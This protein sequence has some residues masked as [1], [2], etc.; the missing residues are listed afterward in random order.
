MRR[1]DRS[2]A[3]RTRRGAV[4]MGS[5]AA[6]ALTAI[7]PLSAASADEITDLGTAS[8]HGVAAEPAGL[9]AESSPT[10]AWLVETEGTPTS[11]GGSPSVNSRHAREVIAE[12]QELGVDLS[13]RSE[14]S[15]LWTGLSVTMSDADAALLAGADGVQAV[16]PVLPLELPPTPTS[17][18]MPEMVSA[19]TMTGADIAQSELGY[20][21]EGIAVGIIDTGVDYHHPDLGGSGAETTFPTERVPVGYDFVGD[22]YNADDSSVDYQPVPAPDPDPDDC[23]SHGTHVA[24]IVGAD[25]DPADGG[26]R[27]VAPGVTFGAYRVFGCD[28]STTSDIMIEAMER[29]LDDGMDVVNMSIGAAF[30]SWPE[31][32]T[33]VASAAL[34]DAGVVVVASIGNEGDLGLWAAGAPGVGDDV[35][36]VASYDNVEF[37]A[38]SFGTQPDG[39]VYP[40]ISAAGA[41]DAPTSGELPL[42]IA[43]LPLAC[44]PLAGDYSGQAVVVQR[45]G[46]SFHIKAVNAQDA[47][48]AAMVLYNN[49]P[50][51]VSPTVEGETP[52]TIA[53]PS[54]S[55]DDGLALVAAIEEGQ[56][57]ELV[58]SDET[59]SAPNPTGGLI[60]DFSS[61]GMTADL[62]LKPDLG[63]PGGQIWSTMPL[64]QGGYG[65]KSGTSMAS[66][67]V[68]GAIALLLQARDDLDP[69]EIKDVL[70]NSAD[71][72]LWSLN[73]DFGLLEPVFR[74][75][76]GMLDIDAA[77]LSTTRVSPG[78]IE[79]GESEHGP[80]SRTVTLHNDG[81]TDVTYTVSAEDAIATGGDP[82]DPTFLYG[83]SSVDVPAQITVP[84]GSSVSV[85]VTIAPSA[86]LEQAQYGGYLTLMPE[87]GEPIRVPYVGYA[88]DYQEVPLLTDIGYG[89]PV[90]GQLTACDRLIGAD[91]TMNGEWDLMPDGA[92]YSMADGDVPT[93]L[94]HLEHPAQSLEMTVYAAVDGE[95]GAAIGPTATFLASE[96]VGRSGGAEAF[97]PYTWDGVLASVY[98]AGRHNTEWSVPDG[99]YIIGLTVVN[100]LGDP[101]NPD[102]VESA[103][104]A[105]FTID[106]DGDGNP[107]SEFREQLRDVP[108]K[109][110]GELRCIMLGQC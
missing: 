40:Y 31:Y 69:G 48:A 106:R 63:A 66:P 47:G 101:E 33:A 100:A 37:M 60:S 65:S 84:A 89:L 3:D 35:I 43:D 11:R 76:A 30:A 38:N 46:C 77:I 94:V 81:G 50:G 85:D 62:Q 87:D 68:A 24:G 98:R 107:P 71:P 55:L 53:V 57:A 67:H 104:T 10:G 74:Q 32:P 45:G 73:T 93:F 8:D 13:V 51:L 52:I 102:H 22:D 26:V 27:G 99:D 59:I 25:G 41:A 110:K 17:D 83:V 19:I 78:A 109:M 20:D 14:L 90:L 75:G 64:E 91:C 21:G 105:V 42:A 56:A 92:T 16:F 54:L 4:A 49:A 5:A 9:Q 61:Y 1:S 79:L 44:E 12:A 72:T 80:V 88:G 103:D 18:V 34:V 2:G 70:Q 28:G 29:A 6:L 7:I 23:Q 82:D 36:G 39:A 97:T 15:S 108:P 95:R 58:W 86:D 96:Y